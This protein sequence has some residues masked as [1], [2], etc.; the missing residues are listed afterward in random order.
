MV[1]DI[2]GMRDCALAR[3]GPAVIILTL[4]IV[5]PPS[6]RPLSFHQH[7]YIYQMS[8]STKLRRPLF[9]HTLAFRQSHIEPCA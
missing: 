3:V 8:L 9:D 4:L 6:Q 5:A 1:G 7:R 2:S